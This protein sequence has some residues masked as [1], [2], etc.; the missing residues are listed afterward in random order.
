M[1][2]NQTLNL[3]TLLVVV[4]NNCKQRKPI[5][6]IYLNLYCVLLHVSFVFYQIKNRNKKNKGHRLRVLAFAHPAL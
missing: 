1:S 4:G 6:V 3:G 5:N 2:L